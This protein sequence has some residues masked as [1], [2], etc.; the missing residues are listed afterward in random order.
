MIIII[1]SILILAILLVVILLLKKGKKDEDKVKK[2]VNSMKEKIK[3][4]VNEKANDIQPYNYIEPEIFN[5]GRIP[6]PVYKSANQCNDKVLYPVNELD[7]NANWKA[8]KDC[9][10]Y[11]FIQPP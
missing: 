3:E 11:E 1:V 4:K 8:K 5:I 9:P 2:V 7:P 6:M 10:C